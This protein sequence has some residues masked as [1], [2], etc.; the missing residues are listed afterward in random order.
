MT[1]VI[2]GLLSKIEVLCEENYN[3]WT[4]QPQS[5]RLSAEPDDD[6]HQE[7]LGLLVPM[8]CTNVNSVTKLWNLFY[9]GT[10]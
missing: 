1:K 2:D 7:A 3:L 6:D 9:I 10:N 8:L 5:S 4:R